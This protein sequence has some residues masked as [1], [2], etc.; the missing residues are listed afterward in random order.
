MNKIKDNPL[1]FITND[2]GPYTTGLNKLINIVKEI[3][4]N[5]FVVVPENNCSGFGHSIT[6]YHPLRLNKID[7]NFYTCNG[8]PTDCVMLGFFNILKNSNPD[9]LLSGIN[10][11]ENLADDASYSGT[12]C[13]ALEGSLRNI[14]SVALSKIIFLMSTSQ[15]LVLKIL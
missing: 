9:L 12:T 7:N 1:I 3:T 2:D 6:L 8:T 5:Y 10:M 14:K 4:N 13:A 11:G 15:M